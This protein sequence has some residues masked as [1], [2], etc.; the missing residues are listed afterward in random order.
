[1]TKILVVED[2]KEVLNNISQL[3]SISGYEVDTA[4]NGK[5]G[6]EKVTK[7]IPDLIISDIMMPEMDGNLFF[8]EL[9]KNPITSLI[10]FIFLTAKASPDAIREGMKEGADDYLVKPFRAAD[11]LDA[12]KTRLNKKNKW[13]AKLTEVTSNISAYV[14]HELR[15]PLGAIM[16]FTD[17]LISDFDAMEKDEMLEM[18]QMI[19]TSSNRLYKTVEKFLLLTNVVLSSNGNG[20]STPITNAEIID[21]KTLVSKTARNK[22]KSEDRIYD[23]KINLTN[24]SIRIESDYLKFII[25]ELIENSMK[26]SV[27]GNPI[28]ISNEIHDEKVNIKITD[29][30]RGMT[31]EEINTIGPFIQHNRKIYEQQGNGL[32]LVVVKKLVSIYGGEINFES[33]KDNHTTITLT[34]NVAVN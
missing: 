6:L 18:L 11:L 19:K 5:A 29:Y 12:V 32:G 24:A 30:G 10:P 31:N 33:V 34:F 28:E 7:N 4:I 13:D 8:N 27:K 17:V 1:M 9:K 23:L 2:S 3:L 21:I 22:M 16:G 14:P 15:T 26:F 25:E 20:I